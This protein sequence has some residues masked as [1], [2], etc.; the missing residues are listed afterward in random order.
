MSDNNEK[1]QEPP[2]PEVIAEFDKCPVCG[3]PERFA[4]TLAKEAKEKGHMA[5]DYEYYTNVIQGPVR[6][7]S[8]ENKIP[9]GA[10]IT[11]LWAGTD[12]CM[13]CGT[14]YGLKLIKGF[15]HKPAI[16]PGGEV[17]PPGGPLIIGRG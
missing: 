8:W 5:P 16:P 13:N 9:F 17:P 11:A 4:E 14:M 10:T 1:P 2:R 6:Q 7:A 12:I 15:A 3:S